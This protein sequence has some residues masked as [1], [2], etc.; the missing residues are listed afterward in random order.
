[1]FF[2]KDLNADFVEGVDFNKYDGSVAFE[3]LNSYEEQYMKKYK[4]HNDY[5][6]LKEA[7]HLWV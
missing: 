4:D 6:V 3:V 7:I 1:M 2:L 5:S